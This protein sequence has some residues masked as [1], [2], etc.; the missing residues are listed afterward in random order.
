MKLSKSK[1]YAGLQELSAHEVGRPHFLMRNPVFAGVGSFLRQPVYDYYGVAANTATTRQVLFT[2][3]QGGNYTPAGGAQFAKTFVHTSLTQAGQL[4]SPKR[5]L[6]RNISVI[7]DAEVNQL[8]AARF[9]SQTQL[10]FQFSDGVFFLDTLVGLCGRGALAWASQS[11]DGAAAATAIGVTGLGLPGASVGYDVC[12][13]GVPES[14]FGEDIVGISIGQ[15][16]NFAV[17]LD[18]TQAAHVAAVGFT[19]Q[20]AA[21]VPGGIGIRAWVLLEG[22]QARAVR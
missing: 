3:A 20:L 12:E 18:P 10:R 21:A 14:E 5:Q 8:D 7:L 11:L 2:I 22:M 19:T 16:E 6:V 4:E 15:T 1:K 13:R 9:A 17:V